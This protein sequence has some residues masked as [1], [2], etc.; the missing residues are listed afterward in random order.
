MLKHVGKHNDR[1]VVILFRQVPAED[2]MALV[3]YSDLLPRLIHDEVMRCLES[4][5][6]QQAKEFSDALFRVTMADGRNALQALHGEGFIKKV[7]TNQIIVT[8]TTNASVR[9][10][11]LNNILNEMA[12]GEEAVKKLAE[13]DASQGATG[14]QKAKGRDVGEPVKTTSA[15]VNAKLNEVLSDADLAKERLVQ[16][17]KMKSEASMLLA[18]AERL[19]AEAQQLDPSAKVKNGSRSKKVKTN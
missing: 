2:H 19:M 18:E 10:D 13:L 17:E 12:K 16:A 5:V 3:V 11:E 4:A 14:K 8:P 7:P 1:K 6:G 15:D 9:L